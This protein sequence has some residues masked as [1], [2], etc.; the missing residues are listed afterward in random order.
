M[1]PEQQKIKW[2]DLV[3]ALGVGVAFLIPGVSGGTMALI[4]N[5]YDKIIDAANNI[6][7]QFVF[8]IKTLLPIL[9]GIV[10]SILI[11][12]YPFKLAF[13]HIMFAVLTLFVGFILGGLPSLIIE[14]KGVKVNKLYI[15]LFLIS[16]L[17]AASLGFLSVYFEID[18]QSL[19][20]SRPWWL[21]FL[22]AFVGIIPGFALVV[23]GISG[24]MIMIVLG[25]YKPNISMITNFLTWTNVGS[26][27]G[28]YMCLACGILAGIL[29]A[30]K[31][32]A[33]VLAKYRVSTFYMIIGVIIGSIISMFYNFETVSY[34]GLVGFRWWEILL[35][36][37]LLAFGIA[38]SLKISK[39][40]EK[41]EIKEVN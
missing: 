33:L 38:V 24:S 12:W 19:Y 31:I 8:S 32:M 9:L 37:I 10:I 1:Q 21:Y 20:D 5:L 4:F 7:K 2:V 22:V 23:P 14:V 30:S 27:L 36:G 6:F 16:F 15:F 3:R 26:T 17:F 35:A 25:F 29:M 11:C 28:L 41:K 18:I 40:G 13:E 34:Y 39:L